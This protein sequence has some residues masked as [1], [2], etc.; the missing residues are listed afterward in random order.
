MKRGAEVVPSPAPLLLFLRLP[1]QYH[2]RDQQE[3]IPNEAS[4][5][6]GGDTSRV[7]IKGEHVRPLTQL[8]LPPMLNPQHLRA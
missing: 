8:N 3:L 4:K 5:R 1:L 6:G 2:L 7:S